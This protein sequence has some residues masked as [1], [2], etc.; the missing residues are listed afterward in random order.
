MKENLQKSLFI[1]NLSSHLHLPL[2][3][4]IQFTNISL[5]K[6]RQK[7][8]K[9]AGEYLVE[10]KWLSEEIIMK[11]KDLQELSSLKVGESEFVLEEVDILEFLKIFRRQFQ[12]IADN[13]SVHF[14]LSS[15][16]DNPCV[17]A[18]HNKLSKVV[19]ILLRNA[20]RYVPEK[21]H[22]EITVY[23]ES[24]RIFFSIFNNGSAIPEEKGETLF[25]IFEKSHLDLSGFGLSI[26]KEL[27]L[28][29]NGDI[30][31]KNC[32]EKQGTHFI[33]SL[34]VAQTLLD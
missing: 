25:S 7:Q 8:N 20:F 26:C 2:E 31:L 27:M 28:G 17:L 1:K 34:P 19:T 4:L 6:I 33:C 13:H 11:V 22:V 10:M 3:Q 23:Q 5:Q 14:T 21:G 30:N 24:G 15:D 16:A 32:N 18:D 12:P 9:L 29:Q